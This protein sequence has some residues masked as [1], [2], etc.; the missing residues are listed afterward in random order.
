MSEQLWDKIKDVRVAMLT[1]VEDNS[2]LR[3]RPMYTQQA[4]FDGELWFFTADDS[5]KVEEIS[6]EH[7][8]N[9][10]Y[11]EPKNSRYVSVSG[12]A[13]LV[14]DRS[15]LEEL[16]SPMLK[17]WFKDGLDDPHLA[18]LRVRVTEAEYWDDTSSKMS[19]L[20]GMVKAA[21]TNDTYTGT[22]HGVVK[23]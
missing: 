19:Q 14:K 20:F 13:E 21:V 5:G 18:L 9:L 11:A 15:K 17:A 12:V 3:S 23:P 8:V 22:E 7:Q 4:E 2:S 16:W 6:R 10:S 1:T